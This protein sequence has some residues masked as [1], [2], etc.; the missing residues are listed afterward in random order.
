V[1]WGRIFLIATVFW[2]PSTP[3]MRAFQ[4]SAMPPVAIFSCRVYW[5]NRSPGS[6]PSGTI[7][8]G[9]VAAARAPTRR[10]GVDGRKAAGGAGGGGAGAGRAGAAA[11]GAGVGR[12]SDLRCVRASSSMAEKSKSGGFAGALRTAVL[13]ATGATG[14][15]ATGA[16]ALGAGAG[17]G[18]AAT[19]LGGGGAVGGIAAAG[20]GAGVAEDGGTD[21]AGVRGGAGFAAG[22]GGAP[23]PARGRLIRAARSSPGLAAVGGVGAGRRAPAVTRGPRTPERVCSSLRSI[24]VSEWDFAG[25]L[26]PPLP[27]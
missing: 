25:V 14:M 23:R 1:R 9:W 12:P 22:R 20:G 26:T 2:K 13:S 6:R 7:C 11:K 5:P 3:R 15:G 21:G 16:L 17:A 24:W 27:P 10:S 18:A 19:A 8:T 4:T